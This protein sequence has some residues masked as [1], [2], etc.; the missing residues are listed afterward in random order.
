MKAIIENGRIT[1]PS[2]VFEKGYLPKNGEIEVERIKR[3]LRIESRQSRD[4]VWLNDP[5]FTVKAEDLGD[6]EL[7]TKVDEILYEGK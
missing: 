2:E 7:S 1:L 6:T 3:G 4:N 5:L